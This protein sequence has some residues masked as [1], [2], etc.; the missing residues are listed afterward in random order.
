MIEKLDEKAAL[1]DSKSLQLECE[2][3]CVKDELIN[4]RKDIDTQRFSL[5]RQVKVETHYLQGKIDS[6]E[7]QNVDEYNSGLSLY[8]DCIMFM[9]RK[10]CQDLDKTKLQTGVNAYMDEQNKEAGEIEAPPQFT[11]E[12]PP[13]TTVDAAPSVTKEVPPQSTA[14][15]AHPVVEKPQG[16]D[17]DPSS[18][19]SQNFP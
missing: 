12:V 3:S 8:Y 15:A 14:D 4:A 13:Q 19:T 10:K 17:A 5:Q 7:K 16:P 11:R 2:L 18:R 6:L 1:S 9:L